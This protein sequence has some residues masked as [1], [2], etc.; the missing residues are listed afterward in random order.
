MGTGAGAGTAAEDRRAAVQ[1]ALVADV[2]GRGNALAVGA[3]G[4][5]RL[6]TTLSEAS[7]AGHDAAL[8]VVLRDSFPG[9]RYWQSLGATTCWESWTAMDVRGND[10][11]HGSRNHAWLCGGLAEWLHA[12]LGGVAPAADGF[13]HVRIAPRV[14]RT[15]GPSNVALRL[16]TVRGE[17]VS[18]WTRGDEALACNVGRAEAPEAQQYWPPHC[19][20]RVDYLP[21]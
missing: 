14:S 9:W 5:K 15:L 12:T 17:V 8:R 21:V 6:L 2:V 11:Y 16:R 3:V 1:A 4:Q 19:C 18:N 20:T 7:D 10:H 13:A